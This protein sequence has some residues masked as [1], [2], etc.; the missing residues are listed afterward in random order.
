MTDPQNSLK[1]ADWEFS[2][3]FY[4]TEDNGR[5]LRL[6]DFMEPDTEIPSPVPEA[7]DDPALSKT[8]A[9]VRNVLRVYADG[10]DISS[11]AAALNLAPDYVHTILYCAQGFAEDDAIA[12]ARLVMMS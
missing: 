5:E 1:N 7:S 9:D 4:K 12:V 10:G 2:E 11:I 3:D 8:I 6:E